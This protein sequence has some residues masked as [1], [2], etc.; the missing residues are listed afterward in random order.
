MQELVRRLNDANY[1]Y[2]VLDDP[3]I[4]DDEWDE[5]YAELRRL[6]SETGVSLPD[7]PTHRVGG[8]I[9]ESFEPHR[10]LARLWSLDKVRTEGEVTDFC[11]RLRSFLAV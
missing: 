10:H 4:S 2:Y 3:T 6:E 8:E 1:R 9:L 7:S 11:A 5:M